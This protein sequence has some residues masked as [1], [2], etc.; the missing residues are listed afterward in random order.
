M[1]N[2]FTVKG[3][4]KNEIIKTKKVFLLFNVNK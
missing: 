2:D 4:E 1:K 3:K